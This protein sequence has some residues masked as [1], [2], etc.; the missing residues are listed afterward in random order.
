M[1]DWKS[2]TFRQVLEDERQL[3]RIVVSCV[4]GYSLLYYSFKSNIQRMLLNFY[5]QVD[6]VCQVCLQIILYLFVVII[7]I[8]IYGR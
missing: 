8:I 3:M 2:E 1:T 5:I 7:I 4:T 6:T